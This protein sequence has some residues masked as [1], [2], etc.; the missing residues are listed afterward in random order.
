MKT[1][2]DIKNLSDSDI[3]RIASDESVPIPEGLRK[4]IEEFIGTDILLSDQDVG[5]SVRGRILTGL[6]VAAAAAVAIAAFLPGSLSSGPKDTFDDPYLAY[7]EV[8]KTFIRIGENISSAAKKADKAQSKMNRPL[9]LFRKS[10]AFKSSE[11]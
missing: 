8:E 3:E 7:I 1:I 4:A 9:E 10:I 2:E 5:L 6:S 11:E